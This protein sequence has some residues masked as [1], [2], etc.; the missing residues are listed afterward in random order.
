MVTLAR[1]DEPVGVVLV[2]EDGRAFRAEQLRFIERI[3]D[4]VASALVYARMAG[5]AQS[6]VAIER[7][8]ELAAAVQTAF[9]PSAELRRAGALDV[10]G[11]WEPTSRCGGDWWALY[12]LS[13]GPLAG[14][15][16]RRHRARGRVGDGAPPP[17]RARATPRSS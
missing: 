13:G 2:P 17:P 5:E 4:R 11:S 3:R 8:V 14:R 6:R 7:E 10:F 9:V 15:D 16:R 1:R 12:E